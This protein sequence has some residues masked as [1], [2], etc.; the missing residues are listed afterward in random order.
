M[1]KKKGG[2]FGPHSKQAIS[3]GSRT[4][5]LFSLVCTTL[6]QLPFLK[7]INTTSPNLILGINLWDLI[8]GKILSVD[9]LHRT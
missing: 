4:C 8:K 5:S 9:L 7:A 1:Q 2:N 3:C 6:Q